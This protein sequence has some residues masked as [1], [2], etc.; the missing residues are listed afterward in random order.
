[1]PNIIDNN[2]IN[3]D[4]DFRSIIDIANHVKK[5]ISKNKLFNQR[6]EPFN[7]AICAVEILAHNTV[8]P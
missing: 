1:M 6:F 7:G 3:C 2:E 5:Y 4:N 8:G